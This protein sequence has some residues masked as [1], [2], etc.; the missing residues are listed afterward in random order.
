MAGQGILRQ[1]AMSAYMAE[2]IYNF[3]ETNID[4]DPVA[5]STLSK[6]G[7]RL[8]SLWVNCHSGK[9]MIMLGC[10]ASGVKFPVFI[11]WKGVQDG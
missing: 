1:I 5:W 4:F 2:Q 7:E 6:I 10:T 3:D 8:V 11:M 9:C